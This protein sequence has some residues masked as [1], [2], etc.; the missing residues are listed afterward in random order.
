MIF[1]FVLFVSCVEIDSPNISTED[2]QSEFRFANLSSL[3]SATVQLTDVNLSYGAITLGQASDYETFDAGSR[4]VTV[5]FSDVATMDTSFKILFATEKKGTIFIVGDTS[6][7]KF[8]NAVERYTFDEPTNAD[9]ALV[10]LL[11]GLP[12]FE[13]VSITLSG[14]ESKFTVADLS[15]GDHSSYRTVPP[16]DY[17]VKVDTSDVAVF[18]DTLA[19]SSDKRYTVAVYGTQSVTGFVDD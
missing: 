4:S 9:S 18:S 3:G 5:Q 13:A 2:Y 15:L 8:V 16:G 17:A 6:G 1:V 12:S 7:S 10:R 14:D 11:N 19:L